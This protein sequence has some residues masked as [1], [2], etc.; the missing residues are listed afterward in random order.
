MAAAGPGII[1]RLEPGRMRGWDFVEAVR[2]DPGHGIAA[3]V[4][5]SNATGVD[6][7]RGTR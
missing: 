1:V 6:Q 7:D 4:A 3:P 2:P 5:P